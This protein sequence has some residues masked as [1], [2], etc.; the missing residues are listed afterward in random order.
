MVCPRTYELQPLTFD[1]DFKYDRYK[2]EDSSQMLLYVVIAFLMYQYL[3]P[4][5]SGGFTAMRDKAGNAC[6]L[7]SSMVSARLSDTMGGAGTMNASKSNYKVGC[8]RVE[9]VDFRGCAKDPEG[10]TKMT[11]EEKK[12][13]GE[14]VKSW[15][16]KNKTGVVMFFA[17]WCGHCHKAMPLFGETAKQSKVPFLMVNAETVPRSLLSGGTDS[18]IQIEYFPTFAALANSELKIASTVSEA[19]DTAA[20]EGTAPATAAQYASL[21]DNTNETQN[22]FDKLF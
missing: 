14:I 13:N 19:A 3:F 2:G 7:L 8:D 16:K 21:E 1:N 17:P 4:E 6:G 20:S 10:Y 5:S 11:E 15:L 18:V 9:L 12:A 22:P